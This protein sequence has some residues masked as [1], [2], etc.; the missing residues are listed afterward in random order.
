MYAWAQK[1]FGNEPE[2][3]EG[4]L[5]TAILITKVVY[6]RDTLEGNLSLKWMM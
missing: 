5:T 4:V 6:A 2:P 1:C 3:F